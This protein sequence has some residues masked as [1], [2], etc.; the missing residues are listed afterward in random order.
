MSD[1]RIFTAILLGLWLAALAACETT[2]SGGAVGADRPQLM[3]VSSEQ[4]DQ[5]AAQSYAKL[6]ATPRAKAR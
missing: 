1:L 6:L 4:L 2:T 5:M 3:L